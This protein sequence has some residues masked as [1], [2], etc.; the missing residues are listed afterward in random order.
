MHVN[1]MRTCGYACAELNEGIL[2]PAVCTS[3]HVLIGF[4]SVCVCVGQ[5]TLKALRQF[6]FS[7]LATGGLWILLMYLFGIVAYAR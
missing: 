1:V 3:R 4:P 6:A 2:L 5:E 7:L